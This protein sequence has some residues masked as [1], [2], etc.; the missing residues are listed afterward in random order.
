MLIKP[1]FW[2]YKKPN[3]LSY[4][5]L[6]FTIPLRINNFLLRF[7]PKKFKNVKTVCIGNIYVGGT[8]KTPLTIKLYELLKKSKYK[9]LTAKKFY[10][11]QLD[12]QML[13]KNKTDFITKKK[14]E[15]IIEI[16][17]QKKN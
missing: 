1:K 15:K 16:A 13:L 9:L 11:S 14:R 5:L 3:F 7:K 17:D 2:D 12:E 10:T 6:I 4:L 8:G